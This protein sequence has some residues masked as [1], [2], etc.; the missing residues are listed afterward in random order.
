MLLVRASLGLMQARCQ[1]ERRGGPTD[2]VRIVNSLRIEKR[3]SDY[4]AFAIPYDSGEDGMT[5]NYMETLREALARLEERGFDRAFRATSGGAL[6]VEGAPPIAP[7]S[8]LVE[9]TVRFEGESDP[10]DEAVLFALRTP[11][12]RIRGTFVASYGTQLDPSCAAA[13][14]RLTPAPTTRRRAQDET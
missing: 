5:K 14:E 1:A 3:M 10:G 9:E 12:D 8:L 13:I 11:D 4:K 2:L 7:E 6:R